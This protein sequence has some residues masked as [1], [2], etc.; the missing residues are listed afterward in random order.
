MPL[1]YSDDPVRDEERY[2]HYLDKQRD[3]RPECDECGYPIEDD[4]ALHWRGFWL[5]GECRRNHMETVPDEN[6]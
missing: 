3:G 5:C 6:Y 4:E 2:T 1:F